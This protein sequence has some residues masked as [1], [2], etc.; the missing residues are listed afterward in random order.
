MVERHHRGY[1]HS[2]AFIAFT[3]FR[4][5]NELW[6]PSFFVGVYLGSNQGQD[7]QRKFRMRMVALALLAAPVF[8]LLFFLFL[9]S[10]TGYRAPSAPFA[11]E[12]TFWVG[13]V[14][15]CLVMVLLAGALLYYLSRSS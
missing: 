1:P 5:S 11:L 9:L 13:F 14:A 15:F 3:V 12:E 8:F 4:K 6:Q 10:Y 7:E 2:V